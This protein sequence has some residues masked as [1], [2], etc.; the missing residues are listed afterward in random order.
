MNWHNIAILWT[1]ICFTLSFV[2][3]FATFVDDS[4]L[5]N[6]SM[7]HFTEAVTALGLA[8]ATLLVGGAI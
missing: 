2:L 4:F 1:I 6:R 8:L 7:W 3:S 5:R